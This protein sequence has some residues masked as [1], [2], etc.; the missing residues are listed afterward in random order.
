MITMLLSD[1]LYCHHC[2]CMPK[3][4]EWSSETLCIDCITE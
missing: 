2:G 4:D 3:P 1:I